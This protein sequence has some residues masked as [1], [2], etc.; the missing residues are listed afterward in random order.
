MRSLSDSETAERLNAVRD[1]IQ[2][3][4]APFEGDNSTCA[5]LVIMALF[6]EMVSILETAPPAEQR[7]FMDDLHVAFGKR[8]AGG[9]H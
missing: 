8:S 1:A 3:A 5:Q 2:N 9:V 7:K 6:L 4:L